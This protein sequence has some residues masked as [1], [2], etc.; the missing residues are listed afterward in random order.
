MLVYVSDVATLTIDYISIMPQ[1]FDHTDC[2][3][4]SKVVLERS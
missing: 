2:N 3:N 1:P 4:T